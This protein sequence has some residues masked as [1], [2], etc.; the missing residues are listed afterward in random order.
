VLLESVLKIIWIAVFGTWGL[1]EVWQGC[2]AILDANASYAWKSVSGKIRSA[3]VVERN[4]VGE[5]GV[6]PSIVYEYDVD[7]RR[8]TGALIVFGM[9]DNVF[10]GS[11]FARRYLQRYPE[12]SQV[13]VYYDPLRPEHSVLEPGWSL[14]T[15]VPMLTGIFML[16]GCVVA[17]YFHAAKQ[18]H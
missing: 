1:Y 2:L 17:F 5:P 10:S 7:T 18:L 12:G 14:W 3:Q 4:Q 15:L 6:R 11:G 16:G 8:F 13:R 9:Q